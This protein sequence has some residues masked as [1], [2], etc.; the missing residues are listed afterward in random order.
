MS[1]SSSSNAGTRAGLPAATRSRSCSS[2][3]EPSTASTEVCA[4]L[5]RGPT[6]AEAAEGGRIRPGADPTRTV[7]R[8][9]RRGL[10]RRGGGGA[11][12]TNRSPPCSP[13]RGRRRARRRPLR[14]Y[15][16]RRRRRPR[17]LK[18]RRGLRRVFVCDRF[19]C[20]P[21]PRPSVRPRGRSPG[22]REGSPRRHARS[23]SALPRGHRRISH[24]R[25]APRD[26]PPRARSPSRSPP[27]P[28][29]PPPSTP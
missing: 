21:P 17:R 19:C 16:G 11:S 1:S 28:P 9:L 7:E 12:R 18:I 29:P 15:R 24:R 27:P 13:W 20:P 2:S 5:D 22:T 23:A 25:M 10:G 8:G 4:E 14:R 26:P 6:R 3:E